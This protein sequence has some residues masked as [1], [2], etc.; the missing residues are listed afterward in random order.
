[1]NRL[2]A[3]AAIPPLYGQVSVHAPGTVDLPE[4]VT[5]EE[6]A[7]ASEHAAVIATQMDTDG[8]V[9][10]SVLEGAAPEAGELVLDAELS[11]PEASLE[12]GSIV[13]NAL[14]RVRLSAAGYTHVRVYAD[15]PGLARSVAV[16]LDP[17]AAS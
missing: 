1:M 3:T 14:H 5:R 6:S 4:W 2:L 12:F 17:G 7:L 9:V 13:A 15:P 8:D 16:V 10:V 11:F